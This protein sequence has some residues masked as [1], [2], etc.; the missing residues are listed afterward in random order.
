MAVH[1][2][3]LHPRIEEHAPRDGELLENV[4]L[5]VIVGSCLLGG[6]ALG[7][8]LGSCFLDFLG[9][10]FLAFKILRTLL[11]ER[12]VPWFV[13]VEN[14]RGLVVAQEAVIRQRFDFRNATVF[15]FDLVETAQE[16]VC[17]GVHAVALLHGHFLRVG[18]FLL[19]SAVA[20]DDFLVDL[21][22]LV[23]RFGD[24]L[25]FGWVVTS[26]HGFGN[27]N[28]VEQVALQGIGHDSRVVV[29]RERAHGR[30]PAH[31]VPAL[32]LLVAV[33]E[34]HGVVVHVLLPDALDFVELER[35]MGAFLPLVDDC[36][37][38]LVGLA[39]LRCHDQDAVRVQLDEHQ[40]FNVAHQMACKLQ[41]V[42]LAADADRAGHE[43]VVQVVVLVECRAVRR[44]DNQLQG[45]GRGLVASRL[46][47]QA[48]LIDAL[49]HVRMGHVAAR[50]AVVNHQ[51]RVVARNVGVYQ[52][53]LGIALALPFGQ[54]T[55]DAPE[56]Q[57]DGTAAHLD[58]EL[59]LP[60]LLV[61]N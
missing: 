25:E 45:V 12:H 50:V 18:E 35:E 38:G 32:D 53:H 58:F 44:V 4:H 55:V 9:H 52:L 2:G 54:G 16:R 42:E 7:C 10:F 31:Q 13:D 19:V 36:H 26:H 24:K 17:R 43:R 39:V 28:V 41:Q 23:A 20:P 49:E 60:K 57:S 34:H 22:V 46:R 1:T 37:E 15:G 47:G 48:F 56:A 33:G 59:A 11:G 51:A 21:A 27:G 30:S 5:G 29:Y 61:G 14:R 40:A 6:A 8:G 3:L